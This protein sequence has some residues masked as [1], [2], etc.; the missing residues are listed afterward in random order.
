[1]SQKLFILTPGDK[2]LFVYAAARDDAAMADKRIDGNPCPPAFVGEDEFCRWTRRRNASNGP[3]AVIQIEGGVH[4]DQV[5]VGLIV[6][7]Q[8]TH[9]APV[10]DLLPV[11]VD[12]IVGEETAADQQGRIS[13]PKSWCESGFSESL[14]S[15]SSSTAVLNR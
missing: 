2:T 7:I 5:H 9:I 8:S 6:G 10:T 3:M 12:E 13:L 4:G 14:R 1:M 11:F 15:A